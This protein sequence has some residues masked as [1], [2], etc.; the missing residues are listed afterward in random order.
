MPDPVSGPGRSP[1]DEPKRYAVRIAVR[2]NRELLDTY[3]ALAQSAGDEEAARQWYIHVRAEIGT[4]ATLPGRYPVRPVE[5][6]RIGLH[7]RRFLYRRPPAGMGHHVYYV[8]EEDSPDGPLVTVV[9][10]RHAARRAMTAKE[11]RQ[12]SEELH[13]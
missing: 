6:K 10:I 1:A 12:I 13:E 8:M 7:V 5:S 4:L 3:E 2:A 9:H 11:G